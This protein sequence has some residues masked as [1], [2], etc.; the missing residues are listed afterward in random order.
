[1][2]TK[3]IITFLFIALTTMGFDCINEDLL[4][5]VNIKGITGT[6]RVNQGNG[7]FDSCKT[8]TADDYLDP[9]YTDISDVRIYDI[10]VSTSGT[11]AGTINN[12]TVTLNGSTTLLTLTSGTT[13]SY[14][15]TPR[16]ILTDPKIQKNPPG[17][18]ALV[19]AVKHKQTV[20]LCGSGSISPTPFPS[21]LYVTIEVFGQ[22][23]AKP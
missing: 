23:D 9:D 13:W 3:L 5:A 21:N 18:V 22:V 7:A 17:L 16:S 1:M 2:R 12:T 6:Y 14:F 4:V 15:N 8:L 10:R 11:Y 19:N 20:T